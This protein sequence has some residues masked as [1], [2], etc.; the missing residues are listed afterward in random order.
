MKFSRRE[1]LGGVAGIAGGC[2]GA[3]EGWGLL[4]RG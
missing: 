3:G 4:G 1:F 2:L